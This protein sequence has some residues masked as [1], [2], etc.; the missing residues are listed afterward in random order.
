MLLNNLN[1]RRSFMSDIDRVFARMGGGQTSTTEQRETRSIPR[2]GGATGHR[3]VEVVRLPPRSETSDSKGSTQRLA[4]NVHAQTWD[5]GFPARSVTAPSP[6]PKPA[7]VEPVVP[8]AH[9]MPMWERSTH[10]PEAEL[11][12][13]PAEVLPKARQA[14]V[15]R[16]RRA[17]D[18][19]ARRFADPFDA[20]DERANCLR[21][22]YAIQPARERRGLMTC[23]GCG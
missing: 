12:P 15:P 3:V 7:A 14:R 5:A 4:C 8:V 1:N 22:G 17:V 6:V 13:A 18:G 10:E 21:C 20:S 23:A 19:A 2:R 16:S 9:V 11:V